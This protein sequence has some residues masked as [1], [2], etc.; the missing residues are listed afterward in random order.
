MIAGPQPAPLVWHR[1]SLTVH[2]RDGVH[3][4]DRDQVLEVDTP[5][6]T[7]RFGDAGEV[8]DQVNAAGLLART[9]RR[10]HVRLRLTWAELMAQLEA[11]AR[12]H[13]DGLTAPDASAAPRVVPSGGGVTGPGG[14]G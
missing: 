9:D 7:F 2:A 13:V 8:F 10:G 6:G 1:G 12:A 4:V 14:D 5:A 11:T 3:V